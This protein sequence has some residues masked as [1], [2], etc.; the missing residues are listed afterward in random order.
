MKETN[1]TVFLRSGRTTTAPG[2]KRMSGIC[3]A[4]CFAFLSIFMT[5]RSFAQCQINL[6]NQINVSLNE[7]CEA[8]ITPALFL[9]DNGIYCE[10]AESWE[11]TIFGGGILPDRVSTNGELTIG[12][13]YG[14]R[15][16]MMEIRAYDADGNFLN[17]GMAVLRVDDKLAPKLTCQCG[18]EIEYFINQIAGTDPIYCGLPGTKYFTYEV[19]VVTSGSITLE[20]DSASTI[21]GG[22]AYD[23]YSKASFNANTFCTVPPL[24]TGSLPTLGSTATIAAPLGEYVVV[25]R[26]ATSFSYGNFKVNITGEGSL[27]SNNCIV[28]CTDKNYP[29]PL[30]SY[31]ACD[32]F[33]PVVRETQEWP[34][35]CSDTLANNFINRFIY[36]YIARDTKGNADTCIDTVLV[37]KFDT[38]AIVWPINY[39][40]ATDNQLHCDGWYYKNGVLTHWDL[41]GNGYPDTTET[42]FPSHNGQTIHLGQI[43]GCNTTLSVKDEDR[44]ACCSNGCVTKIER[45]WTLCVYDCGGGYNFIHHSQFLEIRDTVPPVLTVPAPWNATTQG[46][47]CSADVLIPYPTVTDACT[48]TGIKVQ[49][50]YDD[51]YI[52]VLPTSGQVVN[53]SAGTHKIIY[54]AWDKCNNLTQDSTTVTILDNTAPVAVC[55][56]RTVVSL[57]TN[58]RGRVFATSLDD[59]SHDECGIDSFAVRRMNPS[60]CDPTPI[61]RNYVDFCCEDVTAGPIQVVFRV[62]DLAGNWNECMVFVTVQDKLPP[63]VVCPPDVTVNCTFAYD[64]NNL[65]VFGKIVKTEAERDSIIL[66]YPALGAPRP[67]FVDQYWGKDGLAYDNCSVTIVENQPTV[68]INMCGYGTIIRSWTITDPGGRIATC[69]QRITFQNFFPFDGSYITWPIDYVSTTACTPGDLDTAVTGRP[70]IE[71]PSCDVILM[72]Y[73]DQVYTVI[74]GGGCKKVIR[75][76]KIINCC[77]IDPNTGRFPEWV[78]EQ[79]IMINEN[80]APVIADHADV[81]VCNDNGTCDNNHVDL[82]VTGHDNCT[83]DNELL[84]SWRIF[85]K[86]GNTI[87]AQGVG[88][89]ASNTYAVGEYRIEFRVIDGCG[90]ADTEIFYFTVKNC[91]KPIVICQ[92]YNIEINPNDGFVTVK[93]KWNDYGSHGKC[94]GPIQYSFSNNPADSLRTFTCADYLAQTDTAGT[95]VELWITD[96][97]GNQDFCVAYIKLQNNMGACP[98]GLI[99]IGGSLATD[100]N[101]KIGEAKVQFNG[102]AFTMSNDEGNYIMAGIT[103]ASYTI[104]PEKTGDEGNGVSTYDLLLIQKH[105]LGIAKFNTPYQYVAADANN[106]KKIA[107]SDIVAIRKVILGSATQ[108]PNNQSWRFVD[109]VYNF[110]NP[111]N[112]LAE[113]FPETYVIKN[114]GDPMNNVNFVGVKVGDINGDAKANGLTK[115]ADGRSAAKLTLDADDAQ[116]VA[117]QDYRLTLKA[118]DFKSI[119]GYQFTLNFNATALE[120]SKI[121]TGSLN[122]NTSNFGLTQVE[123]G[124]LT[125]SWDQAGGVSLA[126]GDGLVTIVFKAKTSGEINGLVSVSS[127]VTRAE[128]YNTFGEKMGVELNFRGSKSLEGRYELYQNTP[129]PFATSTVISFN[130]PARMDAKVVVRD[131]TGKTLK[132]YTGIYEKGLN[133]IRMERGELAATG[134]LYYT[135]ETADFNATK[136][137]VIL[138]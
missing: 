89:D 98:D 118:N 6:Q 131:V 63:S 129:N 54:S 82:K 96:Q 81:I 73:Q 25:V 92:N 74:T 24:L 65:N 13:E 83:P 43:D 26:N 59:G 22:V 70:I 99:N 77:S 105:I 48:P 19:K 106:D 52:N 3:L 71:F 42:G 46:W 88:T 117:G 124:I 4:L 33:M 18:D 121:E 85:P 101:V 21:N 56:E 114:L 134:I 39:T 47:D 79:I 40:F 67:S 72:S 112:P 27:L 53:L 11:F 5:Q 8:L 69:G 123:N 78:H 116:L 103:G 57:S 126:D 16:W 90:N 28:S 108:F 45:I 94:G 91:V 127:D 55:I 137:M 15:T 38:T 32:G 61:F 9:A 20:L 68:S 119:E 64:L 120:F 35:A 107:A 51:K 128:A 49:V 130:L 76:W 138:E 41:N 115:D 37:R 66:P 2:S 60:N 84:W 36:R 50:K 10:D 75:T 1:F 136:K 125:A 80:V 12:G 14:G 97:F 133:Q 95:R 110:N 102:S 100:N 86:V 62:Y 44:T 111:T 30:V 93:A 7:N 122:V 87:L 109:A 17:R 23:I 135:L 29:R 31:D 58:G 104:K 113:S 132:V 34:F